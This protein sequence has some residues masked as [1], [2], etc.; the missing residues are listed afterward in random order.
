MQRS[1]AAEVEFHL[2]RLG[3]GGPDPG[4]TAILLVQGVE[5]QLH[6]ALLDPPPGRTVGEVIEAVETLCVKALIP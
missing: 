6:G 3:V 5:A 2:C 4:L 1:I